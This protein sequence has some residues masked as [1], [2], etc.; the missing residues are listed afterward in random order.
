VREQSCILGSCCLSPI[1]RKSVLEETAVKVK[2]EF[3]ITLE[4]VVTSRPLH[5]QIVVLGDFNAV[6]EVDRAGFEGVIGNFGSGCRND[7]SLRLLTLCS[8]ANLTILGSWFHYCHSWL[9]NDG[10]TRKEIDHILTNDRSLFKS[11]RVFRGAEAP[12]N[13]DHRL[14]IAMMHQLHPMRTAKVGLQQSKC[15][16][17]ETLAQSDELAD[18]YNITV[19]N[20][21]QAIRNVILQSARSTLPVVKKAKRP[22]LAADTISIFDKKREARL[23]GSTKDWR[24]YKGIFKARAKQDLENYYSRLADEAEKGVKRHNLRSVFRTVMKIASSPSHHHSSNCGDVPM[25]RGDGQSC[26]STEETLGVLALLFH[27]LTIQ[28]QRAAKHLR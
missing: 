21:F 26:R 28:R 9:S 10:H 19:T 16:D 17:V 27:C 1:R 8:V 4:S 24:K 23:R 25:L 18:K 13:S 12:A 20:S 7:N 3:Y 6:T 2:D 15:L 22:R 14:V 5:D 11:C